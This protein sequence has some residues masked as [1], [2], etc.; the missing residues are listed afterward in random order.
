MAIPRTD[1]AASAEFGRRVRSAREALGLTQEA[2]AERIG[3]H[4]TFPGTIERGEVSPTLSS[5]VRFAA[6][7]DVDAADLVRG[8][9]PTTDTGVK[10]PPTQRRRAR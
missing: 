9:T 7:L 10:R 5:I 4:R 2:L 1:P 3:S 6:A 8:I